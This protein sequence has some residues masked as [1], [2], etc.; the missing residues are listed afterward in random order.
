MTLRNVLKS[1]MTY[2]ES[3]WLKYWPGI[4]VAGMVV[5]TVWYALSEPD[6]R[7]FLASAWP[8]YLVLCL[9]SALWYAWI[10][11]PDVYQ[12]IREWSRPRTWWVRE[13]REI[14]VRDV[15]L[16]FFR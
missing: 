1:Q 14:E 11:F 8:A 5:M 6:L 10:K 9:G 7:T 16:G 4:A 2:I 13:P 12:R 15:E 3:L